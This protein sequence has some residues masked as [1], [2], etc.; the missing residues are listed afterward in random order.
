MR[1]NIG[2]DTLYVD[3]SA[4]LMCA[5]ELLA[6]ADV[7]RSSG[8]KLWPVCRQGESGQETDR[9]ISRYAVSEQ[10]ATIKMADGISSQFQLKPW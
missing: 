3:S 2:I 6:T 9:C 1:F 5:G 7:I 8:G 4:C 10:V